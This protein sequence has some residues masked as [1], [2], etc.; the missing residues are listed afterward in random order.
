M[1]LELQAN[2]ASHTV[3]WSLSALQEAGN[4]FREEAVGLRAMLTSLTLFHRNYL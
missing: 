4:S 2:T 1:P 3:V